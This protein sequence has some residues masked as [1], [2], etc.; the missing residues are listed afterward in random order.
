MRVNG[1]NVL[2]AYL[3]NRLISYNNGYERIYPLINLEMKTNIFRLQVIEDNTL[4]TIYKQYDEF[5]K[6]DYSRDDGQTWTALTGHGENFN[7]LQFNAGDVVCIRGKIMSQITKPAAPA[8]A[9][10]PASTFCGRRSRWDPAK[11]RKSTG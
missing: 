5:I 8:P 3:R 11:R 9:Q 2:K 7:S 1:K 10:C 4:I 6:V